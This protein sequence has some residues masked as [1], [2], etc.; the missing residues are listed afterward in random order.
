MKKL[1]SYV[2]VLSLLFALCG[3]ISDNH[4]HEYIEGK[5]E[6]GEEDPNYVPPHVH[7]FVEGKCE[8]GE[9]DPNYIPTHIHE[10]INEKCGCGICVYDYIKDTFINEFNIEK[11][12]DEIELLYYFGE[13][14]EC[15][16]AL[17]KGDYNII[18][19]RVV[20]IEDIIFY[21]KLERISVCFNNKYYLLEEAYN[22]NI[23]TYESVL[24]IYNLYQTYIK[25]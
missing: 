2:F 12:R 25:Y 22:L 14:E 18:M 6:C 15:Q 3:C 23:I 5:C 24:E 1:I 10:F 21:Y 19:E 17:I 9:E 4:I 16:V 13:Y 11:T 20:E 8:C 7:E